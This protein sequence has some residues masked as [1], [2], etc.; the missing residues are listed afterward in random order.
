MQEVVIVDGARTPIG[1]LGGSL[2]DMTAAD[3]GVAAAKAAM[4][5]AG[6]R[7]DQIEETIF[8]HARQ[9]GCGPNVARQVSIRSGVPVSAPA[10][11][12]QQA[13][14]S[15]M[16]ATSLGAQRITLR[17]AD[18]LLVGGTEH[19]SSIPFLSPDTRWGCRLGDAKLLDAMYKDGYICALTNQHMG[20]MTDDVAKELKVS[21]E[22]QDEYAL[23]SQQGAVQGRE[24]GFFAKFLAPIEIKQKGQVIQFTE[25]EHVRG[26]T[27]LQSLAKLRPAFRPDGSIT[28]GNASGITDG[29]TAMVL[30]SKAKS[31]DLGLK[32]L[33]YIRAS[34]FAATDPAHFGLSPVHSSR[35]ALQRL[36][37]SMKDIDLVEVNEAFAAQVIMVMRELEIPRE[38][39]NVYGGAIS[40]GHPTGNSGARII[41]QLLYLLRERGLRWGLAG[42]CGNGGNGG[43]VIVEAAR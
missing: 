19:M 2:K 3:I 26:E 34:A 33:G 22:E 23:G 40:L 39:I 42:I 36:G 35:K 18:L 30:A 6:V 5:K 38:K 24:S 10:F 29:A 7:A 21:R 28:A 8:G 20:E 1:K 12:I 4:A 32:P 15:G 16:Q 25:D 31:D 17:E 13:C 9:A 27:S 43:T 41:L 11:G 14:V 37:L